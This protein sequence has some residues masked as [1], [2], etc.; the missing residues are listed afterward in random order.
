MEGTLDRDCRQVDRRRPARAKD[1]ARGIDA[2]Y[3]DEPSRADLV[4]RKCVV[5]ASN[6][7][8]IVVS[9]RNIAKMRGWQ[10]LARD[11]FELHD[12]LHLIGRRDR[13]WRSQKRLA[14]RYD[15]SERSGS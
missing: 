6:R 1:G 14:R 2:A 9:G 11:C 7:E 13:R 10:C 5:I 12:V 8:I 3:I 4:M 15:V